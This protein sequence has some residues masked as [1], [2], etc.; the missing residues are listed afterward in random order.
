LNSSSNVRIE[1]CALGSKD[2]KAEL[3]LVGGG[4]DGCN[5]LRPPDVTATTRTVLVDVTSLDDYLLKTS[6][7]IV[8][9]VKLDV[10]GAERE[11]LLGASGLLGGSSRPVILAEV[12]D[13]RTR[14]WGY[15]A[16]EIVQL[17]DRV[18]YNWFR[19]LDNGHLAPAETRDQLYDAN[20]VAIPGDRLADVFGWLGQQFERKASPCK[21]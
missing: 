10:E 7:S 11:V 17:L 9:F 1:S 3:F 13:I 15:P 5:S 6:I 12:Q 14:P 8:D 16:S 21:K 2:S 4:Q 18:G 19:I 20:L